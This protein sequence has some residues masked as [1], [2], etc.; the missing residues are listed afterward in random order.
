[1][2]VGFNFDPAKE[3]SAPDGKHQFLIRLAKEMTKQGIIVTKKSPDVH[4]RLPREKI[5]KTAKL[6]ILRVDGL[7]MNTRWNYKVKNRKISQSIDAS[8]AIVY[9][10]LFCEEAYRRFLN[11]KDV[12]FAII[13]N[14]ADSHEFRDRDPKNFFLANSKWRPH[15]RLEETTKCFFQALKMGLDA[16][17]IV[18]GKPEKKYKH[19]KIKYVG[20]QSR[21]QL[22][23]LLSQ[24]IASLHLTWLD[25]C[26]NSMVEAIV[27][28][29]PVIYTKC[30][31]HT[32]IGDNSGIGVK[33]KQW[34]F[35]LID[36]YDPPKLDK[37]EVANAMIYLKNNKDK[38]LYEKRDDLDIKT[39]TV[40]YIKF[41]E[42]L[43]RKK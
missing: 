32:Q 30:G 1:M 22:K 23:K 35:D 36:L 7:I 29:C 24:A 4:I 14:G 9:Q 39:V 31:G 12:P 16:D 8:D 19:P 41:F 20:W 21:K 13:F 40:Q 28:R 5:N 18:T 10:S 15:R 27:A 26:P 2:K 43:L 25:W 33:D 38:Q 6:K 34:K 3:K 42:K 37:E 17:L 11:I